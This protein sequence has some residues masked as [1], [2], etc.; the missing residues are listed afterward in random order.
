MSKFPDIRYTM[1]ILGEAYMLILGEAY[2]EG[3]VYIRGRE[4]YIGESLY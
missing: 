4:A 3:K 2:I 1:L